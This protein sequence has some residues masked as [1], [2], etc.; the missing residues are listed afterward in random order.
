MATVTHE[1]SRPDSSRLLQQQ[2]SDVTGRTRLIGTVDAV[3][4]TIAAIGVAFLCLAWLDVIWHLPMNLRSWLIPLAGGLGVVGGGWLVLR[5]WRR[6]TTASVARRL[7][8]VG[9]TGGQILSGWELLPANRQTPSGGGVDSLAR[10]IAEVAVDQAADRAANVSP[11]EAVSWSQ[12][13]RS[14]F[15]VGGVTASMVAFA[16]LCP[17]AFGTSWNRFVAPRVDTPPYSP[18]TFNV[19]PGEIQLSYGLPLEVTA[20][21]T[22]G[23]IDSAS[24][25]LGDPDDPASKRV[26]MF[27]RGGSRWQAV[28]PRVTESLQYCVTAERG[29]SRLFDLEVLETPRITAARFTISPPAYTR[30]PPR[31]G[32]YP[33]DRIAGLLGTKVD[34]VVESD[35]PLSGGAVTIEA[36]AEAGPESG[37][38]KSVPLKVSPENPHHA[39]GTVTIEEAGNWSLVVTGA[40]SV[41]CESP[42]RFEVEL[43]VDRPPLVRIA[44]PRPK[45]YATPD[46]KIPVAVV[47]EDDFGIARMRLYRVVDGSRPIPLEI[48]IEQPRRTVQGGSS[49]PLAAFGLEP[50][51]R[52]TLLARVED[53]RPGSSQ[54]GESPL[55]EIDIISQRDFNRIIAAQQGQQMLENKFRQARRMLEQLATE[56]QD[57]QQEL[58]EVQEAEANGDPQSKARKQELQQQLDQMRKR[59]E[60]TARQLEELSQQ[61]LPLEVDQEWNRMLQEQAN[62]LREA[63]AQAG[64]MKQQGADPQEQADAMNE[65]IEQLRQQQQEQVQQPMEAL[66]KIAPLIAA[67]QKFVQLVA[68]QRAVVDELDRYRQDEVVKDEA[69]RQQI[70]AL[71]EEEAAIRDALAELL[72]EIATTAEALGDDPDLQALK[73]SSLDFVVAVADSP[74]DGE[75]ANARKQLAKFN[76]TAANG[77]AFTALTEMEKFLSQCKGNGQQAANCLKKAFA[78]GLPGQNPGQSV[79]QMMQ[80]MGLN[81]G[82]SSG[83]SMRGNSGQNVGLYG[84]QPFSQPRGGGRG[85]HSRMLPSRGQSDTA[86]GTADDGGNYVSE[87]PET[88]RTSASDVPLRYRKQT[89]RYLRRLAEQLER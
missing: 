69:D 45:S 53:S 80:Q 34:F 18:L 13:K 84:N 40:N 68:R 66:K 58:Q 36:A 63:A 62:A 48:P 33:Q 60:K 51:D 8:E 55:V 79:Q 81:S 25:V 41:E 46:T 12:S 70:V 85:D 38:A 7:D 71:R 73:Q 50:G 24:L 47:G 16:L 28:V 78:P 76:G 29:R 87:L 75:L 11:A 59:M 72:N 9:G 82:P 54:G 88:A 5:V 65:A 86:S 22:G 4:W 20:E 23:A 67:E 43:L 77:H 14:T 49:L 15:A 57:L 83:Y 61:E 6:A 64:Q 56:M 74:I 52:I 31:E 10:G 26:A 27:P 1:P 30:Q 17:G 39:V 21:I 19:S 2:L 3:L 42:L 44:Q 37:S 89:E 32:R 35:R